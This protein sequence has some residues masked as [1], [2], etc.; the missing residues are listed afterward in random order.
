MP[1]DFEKNLLSAWRCRRRSRHPVRSSSRAAF[2]LIELLVVIAIISILASI[3]FP[4]FAQARETARQTACASNMKQIGLAMRMYCQD[5]DEVWVSAYTQ[6]SGPNGSSVQPW[7]GFD[8][9]N[10]PSASPIGGDMTLPATHAPHPGSL[11][12]YIRNNQIRKCPDAPNAWQ[13]ALGLNGFNAYLASDYYATNPGAQGKEFGP[14]FRSQQTDAVTGQNI[15][16]GALDAEIQQPSSTLVAWEHQNAAPECNFLQSPDW[17]TTPP[18]GDY[19]DHF[20]LLHRNGATC[21][22]CD[23]HVKHVLYDSLQRAWFSCRKDIYP[24]G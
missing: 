1:A 15:V 22:W 3:L 10:A 14:S 19:R 16:I 2:T 9:N 5:N 20:H 17:L 23:G 6:G 4:V 11:D 7:I 12:A 13:M 8:N 24:G 18:K 21:L